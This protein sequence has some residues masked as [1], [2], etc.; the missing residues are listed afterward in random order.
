MS[1][2]HMLRMTCKA[3]SWLPEHLPTILFNLSSHLTAFV[4]DPNRFREY[5]RDSD[6]IISRGFALNFFVRGSAPSMFLDV[7]V[8]RGQPAEHFLRYLE[9]KELYTISS[10][11]DANDGQS[12]DIHDI[13]VLQNAERRTTI[14]L[15]RT[16]AFPL[17]AV[18]R[19]SLTTAD[20]NLILHDKAYSIFPALTIQKHLFYPLKDL[21][22]EFGRRLNEYAHQGWNNR[23]FAWPDWSPGKLRGLGQRSLDDKLSLV[24]KLHDG[25]GTM[26]ATAQ[27]IIKHSRFDIV[28]GSQ[29]GGLVR[30]GRRPHNATA[31]SPHVLSLKAKTIT[32]YSLR[33]PLT[34]GMMSGWEAF[35]TERLNRWTI[36]ELFK[37]EPGAWPD[38]FTR[39]FRSI[40]VNE[41]S[42]QGFTQPSTWDYADDQIPQ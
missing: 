42:L 13:T 35:I 34:C 20:L 1:D 36:V 5:M 31:G 18:L 14:R 6:A 29:Y 22:G 16:T 17:G 21:N 24:V 12:E 11:Q 26:S 39:R 15:I 9:G 41:D 10:V 4:Q 23:N 7:F 8:Q 32:S 28:H 40:A 19:T 25:I 37:L 33:L 27:S 2:V 38:G 30:P 3:F